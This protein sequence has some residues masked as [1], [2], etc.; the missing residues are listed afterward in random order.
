MPKNTSVVPIWNF[1][2]K[3]SV[4]HKIAICNYCRRELSYK[5]TIT[6]L[7][8]HLK[9]KHISAYNNLLNYCKNLEP[10][11]VSTSAGAATETVS[12]VCCAGSG[13]GVT[14]G[15]P[16][17]NSGDGESQDNVSGGRLKRSCNT[18]D[19]IEPPE[20]VQKKMHVYLPKKLKPDDSKKIDLCLLKMVVYDFQPFS[21]VEDE[22]FRTYTHA[23]NPNYDIP[24]RK[25]LSMNL[26]PTV[27]Q[28]RLEQLQSYV[29]ANAESECITVDCW[30]SRTMDSIWR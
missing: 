6:N 18:N 21:I 4:G 15:G 14:G 17:K 7:K 27:Y 11:S 23:L 16:E 9:Q 12:R 5:T 19:I 29:Q 24:H 25:T 28:K 8:T 2:E 30:T 3:S 10:A 13:D 1:F 20:K 26:L 22:G